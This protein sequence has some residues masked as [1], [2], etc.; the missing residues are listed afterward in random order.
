[1]ID[2]EEVSEVIIEI[3]KMKILKLGDILAVDG[4]SIRSTV[5]EGKK[6]ATLQILTAY[7]V[8]SGVVLG[9]RYID[10]KTN[11]PALPAGSICVHLKEKSSPACRLAGKCM[12]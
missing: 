2:G 11:Q 10:D 7:F 3:M 1:M 5:P 12:I 8:D 6:Q 4:K 9:Q